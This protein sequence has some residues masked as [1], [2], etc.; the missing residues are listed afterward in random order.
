MSDYDNV[1][2][3]FI[4]ENQMLQSS[5]KVASLFFFPMSLLLNI[6]ANS[7]LVIII[8]H[9]YCVPLFSLFIAYGVIS[10]TL[11]RTLKKTFN[12]YYI[13]PFPSSL[14]PLSLLSFSWDKHSLGIQTLLPMPLFLHYLLLSKISRH[15]SS[16]NH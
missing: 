8:S 4:S 10:Q 2:V 6:S 15:C 13:F 11:I 9:L 1:M 5:D 12:I 14:W 3:K 7:I 16:N